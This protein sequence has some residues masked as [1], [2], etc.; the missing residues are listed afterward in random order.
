MS[1]PENR[2]A[3]GRRRP[4]G[5][6]APGCSGNAGGRPKA[7]E[8]IRA[9]A[10]QHSETAIETL[11][12]IAKS[13]SSEAA[14]VSAAC[15]LLDRAYG[16]PATVLAGDDSM[17]SIAVSAVDREAEIARRQAEARAMLDEAFGPRT[18]ELEVMPVAGNTGKA[19]P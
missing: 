2:A 16:K 18:R 5:T 3:S 19:P 9:L 10:R 15:A 17:P 7:V 4:D 8:D 14:R 6:F 13:G 12:Q 11:V 1:S